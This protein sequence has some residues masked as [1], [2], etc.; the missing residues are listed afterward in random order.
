[1]PSPAATLA[2]GPGTTY[3]QPSAA[4]AAASPGDTIEVAAGTY[5]DCASW[6]TDRLTVEGPGAVFSDRTCQDKAAFVIGG[7]GTVL[8]GLTFTQARVADGNGAGIRMEGG[9]LLVEDCIFDDEQAALI[10][11]GTADA[12]LMMRR[13]IVHRVGVPGSPLA[14]VTVGRIASF[15]I[16]DSRFSNNRGNGGA[17]R[18]DAPTLIVGST[19]SY[20]AGDSPM[21]D[22]AGPLD[23]SGSTFD[24]SGLRPAAIRVLGAGVA[25]KGSTLLNRTGTPLLLLQNWS[26]DTPVL[27]GN[28]IGPGDTEASSAG[29]MLRRAKDAAHGILDTARHFAG[30]VR[31]MLP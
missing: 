29:A 26:G 8:R 12:V 23:V 19:F 28:T 1:M 20:G 16:E 6:Q 3:P 9:S 21:L 22:A 13:V 4:I 27:A 11:S 14:A 25:I 7:S 24:L 10:G 5:Y 30:R 17:V 31:R 18:T 15:R 2:A